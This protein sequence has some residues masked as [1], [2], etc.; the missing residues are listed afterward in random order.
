MWMP[1]GAVCLFKMY[2]YSVVILYDKECMHVCLSQYLTWSCFSRKGILK[3]R[4]IYLIMSHGVPW[5]SR[6]QGSWPLWGGYWPPRSSSRLAGCLLSSPSGPHSR[7]RRWSWAAAGTSA[8]SSF[9]S[10]ALSSSCNPANT[11]KTK[12]HYDTTQHNTTQHS[13]GRR[14]MTSQSSQSHSPGWAESFGSIAYLFSTWFHYLSP[15]RE[16]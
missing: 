7:S 16:S 3:S 11:R 9:S 5:M 6:E 4:V 1:I 10:C 14:Q 2:C 13:R 12:L 15:V 8:L